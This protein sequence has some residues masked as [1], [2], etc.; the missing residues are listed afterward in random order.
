[1]DEHIVSADDGEYE[2]TVHPAFASRCTIT[3][4][5]GESRDLYRQ[6]GTYHLNGRGVPKKHTI[7]LKGK[8][9][10]NR[11]ITITL[12]DASH[13]V[14]RIRVELYHEDHDPMRLSSP[15]VTDT[16]FEVE[17]LAKLCPPSCGEET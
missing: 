1:M 9:G 5:D 3:G 13:S 14:A 17:N 8:N 7:R 16:V 15:T 10:S 12:N 4:A 11:D 6:S 2:V